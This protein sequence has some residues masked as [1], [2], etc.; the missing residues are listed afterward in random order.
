MSLPSFS[1]VELAMRCIGSCV[2]PREAHQQSDAAELGTAKHEHLA[3]LVGGVDESESLALVPPVLRQNLELNDWAAIACGLSGAASEQ[4][5]AIDVV[6]MRARHLGANLG[7][8]YNATTNEFAGSIDYL[9]IDGRS[10]KINDLKTGQIAVDVRDNWQL[11]T[12]AVAVARAHGLS[13]VSIA[14]TSVREGRMELYTVQ[15]LDSWAL[16]EAAC[17]LRDLHKRIV[18]AQG[19]YAMRGDTPTLSRGDHCKY[20]P[21]KSYCPEFAAATLAIVQEPSKTLAL[22]LDT[23]EQRSA[24]YLAVRDAEILIAHLKQQLAAAARVEAVQVK[25]GVL[26]GP[27]ERSREHIDAPAALPVLSGYVG[28]DLALSALGMTLTK[29]A[30]TRAIKSHIDSGGSTRKRAELEAELLTQLRAAGAIKVKTTSTYAEHSGDLPPQPHET[31]DP[32]K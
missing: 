26:W 31:T 2:L 17:D 8:K 19:A 14:I 16:I 9:R 12:A 7:R 11:K 1:A 20:C 3:R 30:I 23:R 29:A 10:A 21:S 4:A 18:D 28:R 5:Y 24:A 15:E 6:T 27:V 22:P 25:P 13:C 32:N